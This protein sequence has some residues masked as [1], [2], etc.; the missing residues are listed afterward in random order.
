MK[1]NLILIGMPG[2]G[3]STIGEKL[4]TARGYKFID[5]DKK[6]E[7][8]QGAPLQDVLE[9]NG[10]EGFLKIEEQ[11]GKTLNVTKTVIAP[12][13][14]MALSE[15]AMQHLKQNGRCIFL[16]VPVEELEARMQNRGSRGIAAGPDI[17]LAQILETRLSHYRRHADV[18]IDC[19][20]KNVLETVTAICTWLKTATK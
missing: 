19:S 20:G 14:S 12:G 17:T 16:D 10:I 2:S 13:G 11:A 8:E 7:T 3:K 1:T 4:A 5:L 6:I 15:P 18:T 9:T